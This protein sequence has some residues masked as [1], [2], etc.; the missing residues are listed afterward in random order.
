VPDPSWK[1]LPKTFS[2]AEVGGCTDGHWT[3]YYY[4]KGSI[5]M[6]LSAGYSSFRDLSSILDPK[7]NV[8]HCPPPIGNL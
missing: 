6:D 1:M 3:V 4:S 8:I 7:V 2:H 5:P